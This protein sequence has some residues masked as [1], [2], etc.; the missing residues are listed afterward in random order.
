RG[1]ARWLHPRRF[2]PE[3][4]PSPT[5]REHRRS[6]RGSEIL[7]GRSHRRLG[8]ESDANG[9]DLAWARRRIRPRR[10]LPGDSTR[11]EVGFRVPSEPHAQRRRE[12]R[13]AQERNRNHRVVRPSARTGATMSSDSPL[14]PPPASTPPAIPAA[15]PPPPV[16]PAPAPQIPVEQKSPGLAGILSMFPGLGHLYLGLYQRAFAFGGAF[17]LLIGLTSH[18][19]RGENFFGLFIAFV[20][21]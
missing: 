12:G 17:I 18:G 9:R 16:T 4:G 6:H 8:G 20:W 21:F 13:F 5:P 11:D 14:P 3:C 2:R 7:R 15:P 1:A 19:G 10:P